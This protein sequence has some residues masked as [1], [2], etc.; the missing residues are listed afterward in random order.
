VYCIKKRRGSIE[1]DI[2]EQDNARCLVRVT[3]EKRNREQEEKKE[4][5]NKKRKKKSFFHVCN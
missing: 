5:E 1:G 3:R 2:D 4:T